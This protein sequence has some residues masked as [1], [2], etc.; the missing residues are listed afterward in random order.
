MIRAHFRVN[1]PRARQSIKRHVLSY[2][3]KIAF[4]LLEG[5]VVMTPKDTG[6]ATGNWFVTLVAPR[7]D[8]DWD[9]KDLAGGG[10]ISAGSAV[11]QGLQ[12]Y[13]AIYLTNNLP[14]IVSLEKGHSRQAPAGMVQVSLDRVAAGLG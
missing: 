7:L 9:Q 14:Y 12:D 10:T 5:I 1:I 11:I 8:Y 13:G 4:Q 2:Q 6:R 3:K